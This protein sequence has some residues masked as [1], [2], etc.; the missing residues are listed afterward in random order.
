M[1]RGRAAPYS[2]GASWADATAALKACGPAE[3]PGTVDGAR[4]QRRITAM[5]I[6]PSPEPTAPAAGT[7]PDY[8]QAARRNPPG[9][10][11]PW[12][13]NTAPTY[14]GVFLWFVF[15]NSISANGL[16]EGGLT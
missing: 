13:N 12:Y 16:R 3:G 5:A 15:W 10:R 7:L 9:K 4:L 11:A 6:T 8:L 1:V 14:A 2:T